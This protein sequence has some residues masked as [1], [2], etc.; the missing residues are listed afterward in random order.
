MSGVM[1]A[2]DLISPNAHVMLF[3]LSPSESGSHLLLPAPCSNNPLV[4]LLW[5]VAENSTQNKYS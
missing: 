5:T 1:L 3:P 2:Y 4:D